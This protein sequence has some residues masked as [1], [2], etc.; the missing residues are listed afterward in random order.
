[1]GLRL[2]EEI[3]DNTDKGINEVR[4]SISDMSE[5]FSKRMHIEKNETNISNEIT[6]NIK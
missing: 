4:K 5:N 2:T 6:K 3:K 1:M